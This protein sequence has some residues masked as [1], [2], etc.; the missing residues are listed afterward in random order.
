MHSNIRIA[1]LA[2]GNGTNAQQIVEYFQGKDTI[3]VA[4]I[5]YNR[6]D[7]FVA[8]RAQRLGVPAEYVSPATFRQSTEIAKILDTFMADYLILAGF[9]QLVPTSIIAQYPSHILNIHPAL[10]PNYGGKGMYGHHVH[11]AVIGNHEVESGITVHLV[12]DHY[13]HGQI[14]FQARCKI[15]P[16]D[17]ADTLAEKIHVLEKTYFPS[18]IESYI[19]NLPMPVQEH[20]IE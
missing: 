19:L 12:D 8:T 20:P 5:L 4:C 6:K 1:I 18:V 10:L 3:E 9:L 14:L 17:T 13:D 2:S 16:T 15:T 7:A 11:E